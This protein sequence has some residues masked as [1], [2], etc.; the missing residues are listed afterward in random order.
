LDLAL[1][2]SKPHLVRKIKCIEEILKWLE[3][4]GMPQYHPLFVREEIFKD[5]LYSVDQD[6]LESIGIENK[7]HIKAIADACELIKC[8]LIKV[9]SIGDSIAPLCGP[10]QAATKVQ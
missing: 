2:L 7:E 8:T 3:S 6:F 10:D 9:D 1:E 5:V 4:I